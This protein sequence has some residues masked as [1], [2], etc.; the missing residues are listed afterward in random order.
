MPRAETEV[1]Q[2]A[3]SKPEIRRLGPRP[4]ALHL[5]VAALTWQSSRSAW[6]IWNSGSLPWKDEKAAAGLRKALQ[7]VDPDDFAEALDGA[8]RARSLQLLRGIQAYQRHPYR[9]DLSDPSTIWQEGTTRL[10]DYGRKAVKGRGTGPVLLFVPSLIN[11]GYILDLA[12]DCS[13]VRDFAARGFR[14]LLVDWDRPGAEE[15]RFTLTDYI[16][17]RLEGALD[18]ALALDDGPVVAV[19]YCMGGLLALALALRRQHDLA[20]LVLMATPYDF[21]AGGAAQARALSRA[22]LSLG[23]TLDLLGEL[24]VDAIQALFAVLDPQLVVRKFLS[25][26]RLDP[27]N[28]KAAA[29]V[30]LE[31]WL[32]DGVPL[33]APVARECLQGWYGENTPGEGRWQVAGRAVDPAKLDLPALS[34]IPA[35]D[36]IVP[37]GS[38]QAL[39]DRLPRGEVLAPTLGHIGMVVSFKARK[40]VWDPLADWCRMTAESA[41]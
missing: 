37:P 17:G 34:L 2:E 33:A 16:A 3:M 6:P 14:A 5:A 32:N 24:P 13:L 26:G 41:G 31:D 35:N 36:R 22:T 18:A 21:H 7:S 23:P 11:R 27:D 10:L 15:R 25:F 4:L 29:F 38:A 9:R 12:A 28:P 39:A 30:A 20:G 1:R 19:G 8:V 40:A